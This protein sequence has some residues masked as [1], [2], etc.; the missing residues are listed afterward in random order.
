MLITESKEIGNSNN[1]M[2]YNKTVTCTW[3]D[4]EK[5]QCTVKILNMNIDSAKKQVQLIM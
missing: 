3:N 2:K 4:M 5:D 1:D